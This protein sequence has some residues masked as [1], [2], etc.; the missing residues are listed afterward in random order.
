MRGTAQ[1]LPFIRPG[2]GFDPW[3]TV[4]EPAEDGSYG[5]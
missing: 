3:S 4:F 2:L 5:R 1:P